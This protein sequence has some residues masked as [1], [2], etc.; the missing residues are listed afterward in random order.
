[1]SQTSKVSKEEAGYRNGR[2]DYK[3][4]LCTMFKYNMPMKYTGRCTVVEGSVSPRGVC[5]YFEPK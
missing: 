4:S 5:D 2:D 1:M 3:C